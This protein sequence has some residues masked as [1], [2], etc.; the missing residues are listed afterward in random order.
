MCGYC[1]HHSPLHHTGLI[2][3]EQSRNRFSRRC[4]HTQTRHSSCWTSLKSSWWCSAVSIGSE[5][6]D[7]FKKKGWIWKTA[8]LLDTDWKLHATFF[9]WAMAGLEAHFSDKEGRNGIR[10]GGS[11]VKCL[12]SIW[13]KCSAP[14]GWLPCFK[15]ETLKGWFTTLFIVYSKHTI[16]TH[17]SRNYPYRFS[18][19]TG[20]S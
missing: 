12:G 5:S 6:K 14:E 10:Q 13:L 2:V 20:S 18:Y 16:H 1:P 15:K 9:P 3:E 8:G 7:Q 4:Y 11:R 19:V 17:S